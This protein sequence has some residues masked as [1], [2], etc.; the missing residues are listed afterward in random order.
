MILVGDESRLNGKLPWVTFGIIALN[1]IVYCMN[2]FWA[3]RSPVA[4]A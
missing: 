2:V 4:S 1:I 3:T